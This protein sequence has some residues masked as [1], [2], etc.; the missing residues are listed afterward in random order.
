MKGVRLTINRPPETDC[1]QSVSGGLGLA[2]LPPTFG[3]HRYLFHNNWQVD[4]P[5]G[6]DVHVIYC[7]QQTTLAVCSKPKLQGRSIAESTQI[8]GLRCPMRSRAAMTILSHLRPTT[9]VRPD[10]NAANIAGTL[11]GIA[12]RKSEAQLRALVAR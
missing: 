7:P 3:A 1:A 2:A 4:K 5:C 6:V 10:L 8:H 12:G 11:H 9:T